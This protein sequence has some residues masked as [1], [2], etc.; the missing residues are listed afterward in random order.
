MSESERE[1]AI[2]QRAY[3]IWE[4]RGYHHGSD[5]DHWL[6]AEREL[7]ALEFSPEDSAE[8]EPETTTETP[9]AGS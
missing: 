9:A 2:R 6:E 3:E 4:Q 1:M 5:F 8:P 7:Y